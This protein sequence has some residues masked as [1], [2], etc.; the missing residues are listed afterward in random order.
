MTRPGTSA[1]LPVHSH[2]RKATWFEL[3]FDLVFVV[4]VA[5]LSG[6]YAQHYDLSGAL[7][8]ALAFLAMWWCWLGH[9][10]HATRFD[11]DSNR[12]RGLGFLQIVAVALIGYGVSDPMG[13]RAW[14]FGGGIAA[15]KTLLALAYRGER[16]WR[17]ATGLIRVYVTLYAV[18]AM[19][20][21]AGVVSEPL[22]WVAWC[23]A[24][25]LDLASPWLVALHTAAV[26]PHPEH[27]PERFGLFTIILLGEGMAAV[28]HALDH[29]E[30]LHLS[31]AAAA[32]VGA[33]FSFGLW[34]LYFHR[35][36][37]QGARHISDAVDGKRLRLWAYGHV[38]LYMGIASLAAGSVALSVPGALTPASGAIYLIG[39]ALAGLGLCLLGRA[40]EPHV[41]P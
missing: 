34:L 40:G 10:F 5:Q 15:F 17:G 23:L 32:L 1:D 31:S 2:G 41:H 9:T 26:P 8:F 19:L 36:K 7:M 11:D 20:W 38:P 39:L 35:V 24:L 33:A 16:H 22:R 6:T 29:E 12:R 18:Q 3:F 25:M 30:H 14:A 37:G 28:V 13:D 4:A 27:L 21:M